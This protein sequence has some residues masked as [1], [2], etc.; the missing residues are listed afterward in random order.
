MRRA[1]WEGTRCETQLRCGGVGVKVG[2][3]EGVGVT[4]CTCTSYVHHTYI[5][6]PPPGLGID[7]R[8]G[9]DFMPEALRVIHVVT[10]GVLLQALTLTALLSLVH[11]TLLGVVGPRCHAAA[12]SGEATGGG[13][14]GRGPS[15]P[16]WK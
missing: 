14:D 3:G 4:V 10:P 11:L 16:G 1:L 8:L 12:E 6:N 13:P 5:I 7:V 9:G 2:G 15:P